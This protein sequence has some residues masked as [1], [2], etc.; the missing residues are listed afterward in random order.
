MGGGKSKAPVIAADNLFSQDIV[1]LGTAIGEGT[2]YGLE[3]GLESFFIGGIPFQAETGELNFQDV[4]V[5][6]RQGYFDDLPIKYVMGGESSVM[7]N[8]VGITLPGEVA[9]TFITPPTHRGRIKQIDIRLMV[10]LLYAGDS[11]G[12]A[13]TSSLLISIKYRKVGD[14]EW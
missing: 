4:C 13:S 2:L 11:K 3:K 7:Q 9:R 10:S 1:E 6:F 8:T 12:N 14:T 5:S